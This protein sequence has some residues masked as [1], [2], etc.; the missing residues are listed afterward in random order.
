MTMPHYARLASKILKDAGRDEESVPPPPMEARARAVHA[1]ERA[2]VVRRDQRRRSRWLVASAAAAAI[3]LLGGGAAKLVMDLRAPVAM[4]SVAASNVASPLLAMSPV[5]RG[6]ANVV[7]VGAG[8]PD[9]QAVDGTP[10]AHGKRLIARP[11]G[12]A[13]LAF[14]SGTEL[15]LEERGDLTIDE[16]GASQ[17]FTLGAGAVSAHVA[18]LAAGETLVIATPDAQVEVRGT[19]F[20]VA[21]VPADPACGNGTTTRVDVIEGVVV[22]HARGVDTSVTAG[23]RWPRG[24]APPTAPASLAAVDAKRP[25]APPAAPLAA[26]SPSSSSASPSSMLTEQNDLFAEAV[27]AKRRGSTAQAIAT[28]ERFLAKY[29]SSPLAESAMA[30]RMRLLRGG[31]RARAQAA[32]R[33][34]LARFP[35]GFARA[36]AQAILAEA[37]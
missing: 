27:A 23:E 5:I 32:A 17:R 31:D 1:I 30:E 20:R 7:V 6:A 25:P 35:N 4:T 29:P 9:T 3:V 37:P 36:D 22:V 13:T 33:E 34:Y 16:S 21:V 24:C 11:L 2:I 18:K 26:A 10:I 12:H 15:A 19:T 14:A 28:F 8:E